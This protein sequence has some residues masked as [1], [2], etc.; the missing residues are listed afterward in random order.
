MGAGRVIL[1]PPVFK[2]LKMCYTK[3]NRSEGE[4]SVVLQYQTLEKSSLASLMYVSK[5]IEQYVA[6]ACKTSKQ[7]SLPETRVDQYVC[8]QVLMPNK[9]SWYCPREAKALKAPGNPQVL[10]NSHTASDSVW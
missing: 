8:S 6:A 2:A 7:Y 4:L 3:E 9:S 10:L 5:E 1:L